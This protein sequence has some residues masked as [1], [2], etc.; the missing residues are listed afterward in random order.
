[1]NAV[2]Y[3]RYSSHSQR[4]ESIEGQLRVCYEYAQREGLTVVGEY[5]DRALTGRSDD[6]P[7][8]QRM[9]KDSGKR[10]FDRVIVYKLDRFARNRYDSAIYK[11]KLK[12]N[13]VK[14]LSAMEN[15]GDNPESVILEAVLEASAEYYSLELS[16]KIKRGRH[17]SATKG[18]FVGGSIPTGYKSIDKQL[19]LDEQKA[20]IIAYAFEQ[21]ANG[22][23]KKEIITELNARG[24]RNKNGKPYGISAFQKALRNEKYIGVLRQGDVV[25]EDGCPALVDKDIFEKVQARLDANRKTGA[26]NKAKVEYLLSGKLFCG[27]C[28]A[29]MVGVSGR[30][31]HGSEH[32][33]YSCGERRR[34]KT[35]KKAHE[36]KGFLEWYIVEQ[37]VEYVLT[38]SRIEYIAES[39]VAQYDNEFNDTRIVELEK[40][41]AKIDRDMEKAVDASLE[42][43]TKA[44]RAK[45]FDRMEQLELQK[46]DL[47]IDLSKLRIA[48]RIRF[49]VEDIKSWL[50]LFCRGDPMDE[51]FRK[52]IIDVFVNSVY[53]YDDRMVVFYNIKGGKQISYFE[54]QQVTEDIELPEDSGIERGSYS[55][56]YAPPHGYCTNTFTAS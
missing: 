9:I 19:V 51:G 27:P 48:N 12:Q 42:A 41:I 32:Y 14:V 31:R 2:I 44:A 22:V 17:D 56:S 50:K 15:I 8:F 40:R 30:G 36:K 10:V 7:D 46:T 11:Y 52:R 54:M 28:G 43:P 21:Y 39:V 1:M 13:G 25:V 20:P 53:L 26:K 38:P 29:A 16:Q 23:P 3:A 37:T 35:C 18:Q 34:T 24:L 5:V 55:E 45:F 33:Y 49:T 6:R 4:E 47:E